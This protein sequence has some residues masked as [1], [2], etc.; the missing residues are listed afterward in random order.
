MFVH[1]GLCRKHG[2]ANAE[3]V[4]PV[5]TLH[6]RAGRTFLCKEFFVNNR[7]GILT[8]FKMQKVWKKD[9]LVRYTFLHFI[10][11]FQKSL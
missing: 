7:L 1:S 9:A 6:E 4:G 11:Y 8:F 2:R 10:F 5:V 3:K